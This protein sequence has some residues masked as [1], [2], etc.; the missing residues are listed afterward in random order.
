MLNTLSQSQHF[1]VEDEIE[2][3]PNY[4]RLE[5]GVWNYALFV[6]VSASS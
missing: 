6:I 2:K 1:Q 5:G 3:F 4:S